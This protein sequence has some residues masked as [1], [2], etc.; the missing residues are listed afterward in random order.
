MKEDDVSQA[1]G[2]LPTRREDR[3]VL[4]AN[5]RTCGYFV[6]VRMTPGTPAD[7]LDQWLGTVNTAVDTLVAR[8]APMAGQEIGD[9]VAAVAVG[10]AANFF[11]MLDGSGTGPERPVGLRPA[12]VPPNGWFPNIAAVG[13][14]VMFYVAAVFETRVNEFLS[15]ITASSVVASVSLERGYQRS[16]GSEAFGY[17]DGLRNVAKIRRPEVVFVHTDGQQPDEPA[18]ADGG[19]Y[20]VTMKIV[21]NVGAFNSLSDDAARDAVIGRLKDGTRLDLVGQGIAPRDETTVCAESV[22]GSAHVRKAGPRGAHDDTEIFRRGLPFMEVSNEQIEVG[23]Q[24]CSF[25]ASPDQFDAVFNDWMMNQRFPNRTDG[26]VPGADALLVGS[27]PAGPFTQI[28]HAGL[29]FVPPHHPDGL[30]A[31]LTPPTPRS[32]PTRGRLAIS[33]RVVDDSNA[34]ARFER[35]GFVFHVEETPGVAVPDSEFTTTSSGRG[36]CPVALEIGKAYEL[37]ETAAPSGLPVSLLRQAFVMERP[38]QHVQVI[39][40]VTQPNGPYGIR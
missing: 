40:R 7:Q 4:Y 21:Q 6:G 32:H 17:Q 16:D 15:T 20:M 5:P 27:A 8:E 13:A 38:N 37:V 25:Q 29:F 33:K 35:G 11:D 14:D 9:K 3:D 34:S 39:N 19:T 1:K 30:M 2:V 18:W 22:L 31:A 24:F 28:Q 36:V 10:F 23:L 12:S 26:G